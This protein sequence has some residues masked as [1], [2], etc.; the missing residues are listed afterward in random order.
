M[1]HA[2]GLMV[3]PLEASELNAGDLVTVQLLY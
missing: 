2:E 1:V 3:F